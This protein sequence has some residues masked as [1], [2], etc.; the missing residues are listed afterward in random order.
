M[1]G[2]KPVVVVP[3]YFAHRPP[4]FVSLNRAASW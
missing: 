3:S 4:S 1:V 2:F